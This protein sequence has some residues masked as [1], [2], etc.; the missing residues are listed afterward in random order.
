MK[1]FLI[2]AILTLAMQAQAASV[3]IEWDPSP[4]SNVA[5]YTIYYGPASRGYTGTVDVGL[6]LRGEV[7][8]IGTN[9]N[10]YFAITAYNE[11]GNESEY[12]EEA[13]WDVEGYLVKPL[14][15]GKVKF[16]DVLKGWFKKWFS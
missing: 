2:L 6:A 7:Q 4:S 14:P 9:G 3:S 5:G 11:Y 12:S 8:G 1:R 10:A 16:L 13:V 15:P